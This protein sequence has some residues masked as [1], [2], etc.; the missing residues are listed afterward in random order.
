MKRRL[1]GPV[2]F[3]TAMLGTL[4]LFGC[5]NGDSKH[6]TEYVEG[7]VTLD[8]KPV[9][10]A[11]VTFAPVDDSQGVSATG[12]TDEN[13]KYTLTVI[14]GGTAGKAGSGTVAGEYYV[15]VVKSDIPKPV[16][17]VNDPNYGKAP[18]PKKSSITHIVPPKY[19]NPRKSKL[20]V[21]VEKG[22]N[23][24]PIELKSR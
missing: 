15:G 7:V 3:A 11:T 21:T 17:D 19:N 22:K 2:W 23:D 14:G 4:T 12:I 18:D 5:G 10:E 13:G 20:K 16:E 6:E 9:P 1:K 24:I 8:D